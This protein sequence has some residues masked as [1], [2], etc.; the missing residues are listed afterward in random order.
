L[1]NFALRW[2]ALLLIFTCGELLFNLTTLHAVKCLRCFFCVKLKLN[3]NKLK[4]NF[5]NYPSI[6]LL[7]SSSRIL[8]LCSSCWSLWNA[9]K[10]IMSSISIYTVILFARNFDDFSVVQS[11]L[12][13]NRKFH[14]ATEIGS[15]FFGCWSVTGQLKK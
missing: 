2:I 9:K 15:T 12:Q 7:L 13:I 5:K 8:A 6:S 14:V 11:E 10:I 4:V 1:I 3:S